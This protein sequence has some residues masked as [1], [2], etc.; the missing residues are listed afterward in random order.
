MQ[1]FKAFY[2]SFYKN[3]VVKHKFRVFFLIIF[4]K[5][6]QT[7]INNL[8]ELTKNCTESS[9]EFIAPEKIRLGH[10]IVYKA[11]ALDLILDRN[12]KIDPIKVVKLKEEYII[13]DG[14]HRYLALALRALINKE[15]I[16]C[17]VIK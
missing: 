14:N 15:N 9:F 4:N 7:Q 13:I 6:F 10:D 8:F 2:K 17:E 12:R 1:K 3:V 16:L 11:Y 5:R